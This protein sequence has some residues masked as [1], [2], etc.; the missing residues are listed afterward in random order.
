MIFHLLYSSKLDKTIKSGCTYLSTNITL[1]GEIVEV[2]KPEEL[3][4]ARKNN[5]LTVELSFPF[6]EH[7]A[8][9]INYKIKHFII[10]LQ[11]K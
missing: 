5:N 2:P 10:Q 1:P 8:K 7:S 4:K 6:I 3:K 11:E 9:S